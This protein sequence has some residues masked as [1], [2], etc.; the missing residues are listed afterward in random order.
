[1]GR[2]RALAGVETFLTT[3]E[4]LIASLINRRAYQAY[5]ASDTWAR[6][7][8]A[9]Q[10]RPGPLSVIPFDYTETDGNRNISTATRDGYE[11]TITTTADIDGDFVTGQ[12]VAIAS[13]TFA[14]A[15][16]N[17]TFEV[18]VTGDDTFTYELADDTLTGTETYGGSGTVAP[19]AISDVNSFIRVHAS[20]PFGIYGAAEYDFYTQNDGAHV[21]GNTAVQLG[22][23]VT[24]KAVWGGPYDSVSVTAIPQEWFEYLAHAVYADVARMDKKNDIAH[25]EER[26]AA[27]FLELELQK[28]QN[29][30]NSQVTTRIST[31]LSRQARY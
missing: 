23:W 27:N 22:F 31:S 18:T 1:M 25:M 10:A 11:V 6:Y 15:D 20:K 28:P 13:L 7:L 4:T 3:E 8:V 30:Y 17:G 9:G 16:P 24:Y 12:S 5:N 29:Q 2:I 21:I 26:I 19:V 14:T